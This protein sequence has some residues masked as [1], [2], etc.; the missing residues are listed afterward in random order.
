MIVQL[1]TLKYQ[2][3]FK[4][5]SQKYKI[6]RDLYQIDLYG[7]EIR[8]IDDNQTNSIKKIILDNQEI[9][10]SCKKENK[11]D[12]LFISTLSK[13][14]EL[15]NQIKFNGIEDIGIKI[16]SVLYNYLNYEKDSIKIESKTFNFNKHYILGILNTTPDS[17]SDGGKFNNLD[18]AVSHSFDMINAGADIID[19]GGE[20]TRPGA[21]KIETDEEIKRVIPVIQKIK[22]LKPDQI[23]SID[24]T[25]SIVAES[26][27]LNGADIINDISGFTNDEN[28][29]QIA[30]DYNVWSILM[31]MKGNPADMQN[32]PYYDE[33]ISEIIDFFSRQ[34]DKA[35]INGVTKL[36]IDP[37]IGFGKRI[38]DN[39]E[40]I[41]RLEEFKGLGFPI[42]IGLSRK[43]FL[44]KSLNLDVDERENATSISESIAMMNGAIFI[45]THNVRKTKEAS[46]LIGYLNNLSTLG[47]V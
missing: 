31:H 15:I 42:L 21:E 29:F 8:D 40:I 28:M 9:C 2:D 27:I 25:K 39:Y 41:K 4:K 38:I 19:I 37:G 17:F 47:N 14:I 3:V 35:L 24:T 34:V 5:Y 46:K 11:F 30:R 22:K 26:A 16:Q 7:I 43:S 36:I 44:G 6:Y 20:S 13:L 33:V 45:R 23:I 18:S 32:N 10:Y 12:L 1:I